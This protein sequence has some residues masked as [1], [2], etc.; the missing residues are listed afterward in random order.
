MNDNSIASR[1]TR[2]VALLDEKL[3]G[4][5]A[6]INTDILDMASFQDDVLNQLWKRVVTT[7]QV[8]V[9]DEVATELA[10]DGGDHSPAMRHHG[11]SS[12]RGINYVAL[13]AEWKRVVLA[14]RG[15]AK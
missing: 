9:V 7:P 1:V 14:R 15:G 8:H 4:W 2:G 3:P 13:T 5:D 10:K 6:Y 12:D 11:F